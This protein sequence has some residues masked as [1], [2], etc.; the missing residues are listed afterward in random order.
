M[1]KEFDIDWP[2]IIDTDMT[3][4]GLY[5]VKGVPLILLFGS[6]GTIIVRDLRGEEM[7]NKVA[8]VLNSR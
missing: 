3:P 1:T 2:Q 7:K 8:K 5:D 6:D 4:M